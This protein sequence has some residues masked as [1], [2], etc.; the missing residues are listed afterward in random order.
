MNTELLK[1]VE[2]MPQSTGRTYMIKY[3]K[4]G[5]LVASQAIKAAC[6]CCEGYYLDGKVS[7]EL[8]ECPLFPFMPYSKQKI[9]HRKGKKLSEEQKQK[10]KDGKKKAKKQRGAK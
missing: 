6:F 5:K 10:M 1:T 8:P 9:K 4:G 7:C 3:L 2:K